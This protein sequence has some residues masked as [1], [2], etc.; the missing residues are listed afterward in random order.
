MARRQAQALA[1]VRRMRGMRADADDGLCRIRRAAGLRL[2][3]GS[4]VRVR[5]AAFRRSGGRLRPAHRG[6]RPTMAS[7]C[8]CA[9]GPCVRIAGPCTRRGR[10]AEPP[11][12]LERFEVVQM[13]VALGPR[14]VDECAS[15]DDGHV[16]PV[17]VARDGQSAEGEAREHALRVHEVLG[18]SEADEGDGGKRF[19]PHGR[20]PLS[21]KKHGPYG[22]WHTGIV[23]QALRHFP[24]ALDRYSPVRSVHEDVGAVGDEAGDLDACRRLRRRPPS[25]CS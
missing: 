21:R 13:L 11:G 10:C 19:F 16:G 15:I 9:R 17:D 2:R 1:V 18:A 4:A 7:T 6:R 25:V 3:R 5:P 14:K 22:P 12:G 8:G 20:S 24:H 23:T